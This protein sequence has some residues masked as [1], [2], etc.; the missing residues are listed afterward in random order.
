MSAQD[1][2]KGKYCSS[3]ELD[4]E[5]GEC[6]AGTYYAGTNLEFSAG[7]TP[8]DPGSFCATDGLETSGETCTAGNFCEGGDLEENQCDA[9]FYCPAGSIAP[10]SCSPG[11]YCKLGNVAKNFNKGI[12]EFYRKFLFSFI[13]SGELIYPL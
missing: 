13:F 4:A 5:T 3:T 6:G 10:Q 9:G 8:C 7:C 11:K 1:C 12:S 2:P